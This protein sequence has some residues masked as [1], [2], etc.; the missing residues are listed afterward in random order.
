MEAP[1]D[2]NNFLLGNRNAD[3]WTPLVAIADVAG[4]DWPQ[5]A[6]ALAT[7]YTPPPPAPPAEPTQPIAG[8]VS[9][10]P[11]V[12]VVD[13]AKARVLI[14]L[15]GIKPRPCSRTEIAE[16]ALSNK[17]KSA[18]LD[19]VLA[20][21]ATEGKITMVKQPPGPKG[22]PWSIMV[23]LVVEPAPP[24]PPVPDAP[25]VRTGPEPAPPAPQQRKRKP[26]TEEQRERKNRHAR[27][28]RRVANA[29][30]AQ[31]EM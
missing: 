31:E 25:T 7:A 16:R 13:K 20:A 15:A 24:A 6:R 2:E 5:I 27:E 30:A 19:A 4:G 12:S 29:V 22:G 11:D 1:E 23:E 26:L 14:Y 9:R 10:A 28:Q 3:N 18:E 21:L 8:L 17:I